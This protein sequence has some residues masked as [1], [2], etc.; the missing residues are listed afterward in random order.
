MLLCFLSFFGFLKLIYYMKKRSPSR[1][2][3]LEQVS[4]NEDFLPSINVVFATIPVSISFMEEFAC[5][6]V[7][8]MA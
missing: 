1:F 4:P 5:A 2:N 7:S 8:L 3:I 6:G